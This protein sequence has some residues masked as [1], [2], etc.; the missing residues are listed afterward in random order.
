MYSAIIFITFRPI[1]EVDTT[2]SSSLP[3][4]A[5]DSEETSLSKTP[6][7]RTRSKNKEASNMIEDIRDVS[8]V[9]TRSFLEKTELHERIA[10]T[11]NSVRSGP[12]QTKIV[13]EPT[14]SS[15]AALELEALI[16][17][18]VERTEEDPIYNEVIHDI[19]GDSET[20]TE[21]Q[22]APLAESSGTESARDKNGIIEDHNN[23]A[24]RSIVEATQTPSCK[25]VENTDG[26]GG[27]YL[28]DGTL[29]NY[30]K[31]GAVTSV[32]TMP[33]NPL[34]I[35]TGGGLIVM[36]ETAP[37]QF[38][39]VNN[40]P[41]LNVT[42]V[43]TVPNII[44]DNDIISMPTI[45]VQDDPKVTKPKKTLRKIAAKSVVIQPPPPLP[46][47]TSITIPEKPKT[48]PTPPTHVRNLD[49]SNLEKDE[50]EVVCNDNKPKQ[51]KKKGKEWDSELRSLTLNCVDKSPTP[52]KK[53]TPASRRKKKN[54]TE[55]TTVE[56]LVEIEVPKTP[57]LEDE[58]SKIFN[59]PFTR[60]LEEQLNEVD[61]QGVNTPQVP[62]TPG[63]GLTPMEETCNK[64]GTDYSTS[65]SYYQPPSDTEQNHSIEQLIKECNKLEKEKRVAD[66]SDE[67]NKKEDDLKTKF[68]KN[69]IGKKNLNLMK[70]QPT[71]SSSSSSSEDSDEDLHL[72]EL[73]HKLNKSSGEN[74]I[75]KILQN[76]EIKKTLDDDDD[77]KANKTK[78]LSDLEKVRKRTVEYIKKAPHQR[79]K[80]GRKPGQNKTKKPPPPPKTPKIPNKKAASAKKNNKEEK[81]KES[82]EADKLVKGLAQRG[83]HLVP[84]KTPT[85]KEEIVEEFD[86]KTYNTVEV[87]KY[88]EAKPRHYVFDLEYLTKRFMAD[89]FIEEVQTFVNT[90]IKPTNLEL[91]EISSNPAE[92]INETP[93]DD[94]LMDLALTIHKSRSQSPGK[95]ANK[96]Y[97]F[98]LLRLL[99]YTLNGI[100]SVGANAKVD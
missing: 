33:T 42:S 65:S 32:P 70:R 69:I 37:Q 34:Y 59:T 93:I 73:A 78:L 5:V 68:N 86:R 3:G 6:K 61:I 35:N 20:G 74:K 58:A 89:V 96:R 9:F 67:I 41:L 71:V 11:I 66:T 51:Q 75:C 95:I 62:F 81:S 27:V 19:I 82:D 50:V 29:D 54:S 13:D 14:I 17:T 85:K 48:N 45:I 87:V 39:I 24:V 10:D 8:N 49:F 76:I 16:R 47:T 18:V 46:L 1:T 12:D 38:Y 94:D 31:T 2:P 91:I 52:R 88:D 80:R 97:V 92:T 21:R 28:F 26:G 56:S 98:F 4:N 83:I 7:G 43:P 40:Q 84:N 72:G 64:R 55:E 79:S 22:Q 100:L 99:Y 63:F 77:D 53:K 90:I 25:P 44:T 60:A 15:G 23:E 36:P 57:G 30:L